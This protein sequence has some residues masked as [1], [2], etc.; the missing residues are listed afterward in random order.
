MH[1]SSNAM[2]AGRVEERADEL[3]HEHQQQIFRRTDHL[4]AGLLGIEWLAAIGVALWVSPLA[5][6]GLASRTHAHVYQALG[7]GAVVV[8]FPILLA[9]LQPG[10]TLTRHVIGMGQ[11]V[12]TGLLIHLTGGRLETHFLFFGSLAFLAFYR[13]WKVLISASAVAAADHLFRELWWPES[14]YGVAATSGWRWV[15]HAW[16]VVFENIFLIWACVQCVAEMRDIAD[17]RARLELDQFGKAAQEVDR[18]AESVATASKQFT[19]AAQNLSAGSQQQAAALEATVARLQEISASIKQN[20]NN[21][22]NAAQLARAAQNTADNGGRV[23]M[24]AVA[25]MHDITQAA[26]RIG[27]I[28]MTI[29]EIAFQT[30]LLALNAAV[31]AARAGDQGRGFAVV[32]GEVQNLA[33]RSAGAAKQIKALIQDSGQKVEAGS[34]LVNRSGQTLEE[35]VGAVRRVTELMADIALT[36]REQT[37]GMNQAFQAVSQM[38]SVVQRHAAE[39]ETLSSTAQTLADQAQVLLNLIDQ[40]RVGAERSAPVTSVN[41]SRLEPRPNRTNERPASNGHRSTGRNTASAH[42]DR[43]S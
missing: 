7:F 14:I 30:N 12:Y 43:F 9:F 11:M 27:D 34:E 36:S 17:Q 6:A 26:R 32:A 37:T 31:E 25:A 5:W 40:V 35:I 2:N 10:N 42:P 33:R 23:V 19:G 1:S 24:S 41:L 20:A 16:W 18:A 15:E 22:S 4:L 8:S 39:A 28:I 3:F 29:D 21:A 38:D 13:D